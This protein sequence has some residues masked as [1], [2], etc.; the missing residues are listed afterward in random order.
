MIHCH[1]TDEDEDDDTAASRSVVTEPEENEDGG[2]GKED[3][4]EESGSIVEAVPTS[5]PGSSART[6]VGHSHS[7]ASL[8]GA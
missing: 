5:R 2:D 6:P 8:N 1:R 4:S 3:G 7:C